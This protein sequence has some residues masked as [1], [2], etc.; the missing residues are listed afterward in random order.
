MIQ[1]FKTDEEYVKWLDGQRLPS[2][3]VV[4]VSDDE[5]MYFTTNNIKGELKTYK[6]EKEEPI[7]YPPLI[8]SAKSAG[9]KLTVNG[10]TVTLEQGDNITLDYPNEITSVKATSNT[11]LTYIQ[12]PNTVTS[13]ESLAFN[14]CPYLASVNIP[15]T[16]T[17]IGDSAFAR[18]SLTSITIPDGV[19]SIESNA[20]NG[21]G[22]LVS[23]NIPEGIT[24]ISGFVFGMCT[25]LT[26]ISIPNSVTSIGEYSFQVC[27]S[28]TSITIP[29]NVRSIGDSAF[30][31]CA[32]LTDFNFNGTMSQWRAITLGTNWKN[33][34]AFTVVHCTDGDVSL[35]EVIQYPPLIY[36]AKS[37]GSTIT[38]NGETVTLEQGDNITLDYPNEIT[39]VK[40]T[41]NTELTYLQIPNTVVSINDNAFTGCTALTDFNYNGT[42]EQWSTITLGTDWK[43]NAAFTVVHCTDGDV[44]L[45]EPIQPI[46]P[47]NLVY[48]T[49][50]AGS[51]ITVNGETVTLGQGENIVLDYPNE[52]TSVKATSNTALTYIQIPNTVKSISNT[53]FQG[54]T[55]LTSIN[56]PDTV[57]S[58]EDGSITTGAF[59]GCSNLVSIT[60]PESVK[61]IGSNA[62][63]ECYK[64][65]SITIPEGVTSIG[66]STFNGCSSLASITIPESVKSIGS[67]GFY[68]CS[69]L[70]YITLP[71]G[72][73]EID[74]FIFRE[75]YDLASITIPNAVTKIKMYAFESCRKLI[76]FNYS[77][78]TAQWGAISLGDSWK[79]GAPFTVV[80]CSDGDVTV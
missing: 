65:T 4:Y 22:S 9:S 79:S 56:I 50:A 12:I 69:K 58:I 64:L 44:T 55:S 7:Q 8:Y 20:F 14:S 15:D 37:A 76:D 27:S 1:V 19:T 28:L 43:N 48:S 62:F 6:C 66:N 47:N 13:I 18:T 49:N 53:A 77:G 2:G 63:Q 60:I 72:L 52:I 46:Q 34:A 25:S 32:A 5:T 59:R 78:T 54:C 35:E 24:S 16:V 36:S 42:V 51:T 70:T 10:E 11:A 74:S 26:S 30:D 71:D 38:V 73:T 68:G 23:I 39:S 40:A 45:E 31:Q 33:N 75:C 3:I 29:E 17:S 57:T 67:S 61:S 41:N 80:H 21:C